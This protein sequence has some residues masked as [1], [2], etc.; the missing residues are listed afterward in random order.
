MIYVYEWDM[1]VFTSEESHG[2]GQW[3][4]SKQHYRAESQ[5]VRG[6]GVVLQTIALE[7]EVIALLHGET[8]T[9]T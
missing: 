3:E 1:F 8:Q 4:H 5:P 9:K 6:D 7:Y 2:T